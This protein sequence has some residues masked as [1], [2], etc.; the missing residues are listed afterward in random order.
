M[1]Q[2]SLGLLF[3]ANAMVLINVSVYDTENCQTLLPWTILQSDDDRLMVARSNEHFLND[4]VTG[5]EIFN[6]IH[7]NT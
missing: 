7:S 2:V 3:V 1:F 5:N 6:G 4:N